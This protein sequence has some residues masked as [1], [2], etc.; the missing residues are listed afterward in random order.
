MKGALVRDLALLLLFAFTVWWAGSQVKLIWVHYGCLIVVV[1][2]GLVFYRISRN[3]LSVVIAPAAGLLAGWLVVF[4]AGILTSTPFGDDVFKL[5]FSLQSAP[6]AVIAGRAI[7][8]T[9]A[10]LLGGWLS[11]ADGNKSA[12]TSVV[13]ALRIVN[14]PAVGTARWANWSSLRGQVAAGWPREGDRGVV[15]GKLRGLV[16]RFLANPPVS[17]HVLVVG[18]TGAGKSVGYV[19]PNIYAAA[20]AGDSLVVADPKGELLKA[21]GGWLQVQGYDV[22]VFDLIGNRGDGWNPIATLRDDQEV[23]LLADVVIR[24]AVQDAGRETTY[25]FSLEKTALMAIIKFVQ[26]LPPAQRNFLT[27]TTLLTLPVDA[28]GRL[29]KERGPVGAVE[30]WGHV[31]AARTPPIVGLSARLNI[32]RHTGSLLTPEPGTG[33]DFGELKTRKMALFCILPVGDVSLKPVLAAFY[34]FLFRR[35]CY[36]ER[37]AGDRAIRLILDEFANLGHIGNFNQVIAIARGYGVNVSLILQ[38]RSQLRDL[39]GEAEA[40]NIAGNCGLQI[41]LGTQDFET[42]DIFSRALGIAAVRRRQD[43][44]NLTLSKRFME[45]SADEITAKRALLE[46]YEIFQLPASEGI[47]LI[48]GKPP[49]LFNKIHFPAEVIGRKVLACGLGNVPLRRGAPASIDPF[50]AFLASAGAGSGR[51]AGLRSGSH[52]GDSNIG[53]LFGD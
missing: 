13:G 8:I 11:S 29:I 42:A 19:M 9:T 48:A 38:T 26:T 27:V 50:S 28:L 33:I 47:A 49:V 7:S 39:Y 32:I 5:L 37:K 21:T 45:R 20:M 46:P 30:S 31:E 52:G 51:E 36:G 6:P 24:N 17:P 40:K 3:V 2:I 23:D 44:V 12:G 16:M 14:N 4:G 43:Y 22:R 34:T 18:G 1:S 15:V 53:R 25:F 35:L 10:V 41:L